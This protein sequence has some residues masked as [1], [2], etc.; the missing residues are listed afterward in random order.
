MKINITGAS[1]DLVEIDGDI[2]EEFSFCSG[3]K[4]LLAFSDGTLLQI[5]YDNDDGLWRINRLVDGDSIYSKI[6]GDVQTDTSDV[7]QL[8]GEIKWIV[9][10]VR[11]QY[12]PYIVKKLK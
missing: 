9:F 12:N 5:W 2:V 11:D 3:E 10:S 1:D 8:I 4:G 7:A 6:E